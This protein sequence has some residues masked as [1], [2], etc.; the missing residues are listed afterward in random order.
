MS[1]EEGEYVDV[2]LK[3]MGEY[4]NLDLMSLYVFASDTSSM[5]LIPFSISTQYRAK[6]E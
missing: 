2:D 5:T 4:V 1:R 3:R 6:G